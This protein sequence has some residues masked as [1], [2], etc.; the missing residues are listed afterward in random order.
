MYIKSITETKIYTEKRNVASKYLNRKQLT[1]IASKQMI[2][3]ITYMEAKNQNKTKQPQHIFIM[4]EEHVYTEKRL[5]WRL[6]VS[7]QRKLREYMNHWRISEKKKSIYFSHTKLLPIKKQMI[8]NDEI[9]SASILLSYIIIIYLHNLLLS[10]Y[11]KS[12]V[13]DV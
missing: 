1:F 12:K 8:N 4:R 6:Q 3:F 5:S 13:G 10:Q 2:L 11:N 9:T 7:W